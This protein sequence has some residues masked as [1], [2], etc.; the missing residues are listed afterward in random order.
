[1]PLSVQEVFNTAIKLPLDMQALLAE[2]PVGNVEAHIDPALEKLHFVEAKRR[3]D[4]VRSGK[5]QTVEG[6]VALQIVRK[7]VTR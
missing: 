3:R 6:S 5:V 7:A 4:D 1:M 2:K